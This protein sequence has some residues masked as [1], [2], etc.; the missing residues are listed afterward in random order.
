MIF[1]PSIKD[2]ATKPERV[3]VTKL[4]NPGLPVID[5]LQSLLRAGDELLQFEGI[6][7]GSLSYIFGEIHQ[8]LSLSEATEKARQLGYT[9]P[10]PAEDLNGMDVARKV[11]VIA[12]EAGMPLELAD[13]NLQAVVP[14]EL[15]A[16]A[17]GD[18]FMRQLPSYDA[19]FQALIDD[20][21]KQG[22]KLRYVAQIKDQKCAVKIMAVN[23][24]HPLYEIDAGENA[25][26]IN[27]QYYQ[28]KPFIIRGYGAGAEVT[29]AG[30]FGDLLRTLSWEQEH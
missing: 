2:S 13:V 18:E 23:S 11:L 8:G 29:A 28:P 19:E 9:E 17:D 25:L 20:A 15:A 5:N 21:E 4:Y 27:T 22:Q 7:S 24:D 26:A 12:R 6:L 10:N 3:W 16:L 30:L 1:L 14:D